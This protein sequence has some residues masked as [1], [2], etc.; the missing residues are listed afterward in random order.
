[1]L[2]YLTLS[3]LVCSLWAQAPYQTFYDY[4]L[5]EFEAMKQSDLVF[6]GDSLTM[7]H[8]WSDFK[9]SNMGI[10]GD[11]TAGILSRMHL[12]SQARTI[13][14]M[15]G[16]NDILNEIPLVR[17]QSNYTKILRKFSHDQ[18]IYILSLL[19]VIDAAQTRKINQDIKTMNKWLEGQTK[20]HGFSY[21]NLYNDFL[22]K[23][24]K[25]LKSSF[26]TDGIHLTA[27]AY[28]LW[29]KLLHNRLKQD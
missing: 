7:R 13:V 25:G 10:D 14:L 2:K 29:E 27:S 28:R 3:L 5:Q 20:E 19:P 12:A 24:K 17:I 22:D 8:N 16:V 11:T 6:L 1:M 15:I 4:K 26:T 21:I 23:D 18:N 9:A